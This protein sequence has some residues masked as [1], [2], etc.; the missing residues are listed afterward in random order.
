M[1]INI[2]SIHFTADVKLLEFVKKKLSKIESINGRIITSDVYLKLDNSETQE[3]KITEIKLNLPGTTLFA[4][5][6]SATFEEAA[7]LA[8]DSLRRQMQRAKEK[9]MKR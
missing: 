3:N 1:E 7:D 2:Q 8:V 4:K 5:E 6:Q 9:E